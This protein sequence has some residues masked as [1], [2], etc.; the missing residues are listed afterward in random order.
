MHI[1]PFDHLKSNFI[2]FA[3]QAI[4]PIDTSHDTS[5]INDLIAL[6]LNIIP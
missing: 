2:T 1:I 4:T 3:W 5:E 6:T